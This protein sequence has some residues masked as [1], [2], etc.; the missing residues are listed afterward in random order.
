MTGDRVLHSRSVFQRSGPVVPLVSAFLFSRREITRVHTSKKEVI[1]TFDGGYEIKSAD[2]ILEVLAK[3]HAKGTFFFTGKLIERHP[4]LIK[5]IATQGHEIF[6]HTYGHPNLTTLSEDEITNELEKT[7]RILLATVNLS[8]KPYF[9]AP[10]GA[11]NVRVLAVA[12]KAGYRSVYRTVN[13]LDWKELKG[14]T[15]ASVKER[16]LSRVEPGTIY[17]MHIG[18]TI[19]G[20]I[21]DDVFTAI[22]ARGYHIVSLTQGLHR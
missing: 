1:F 6:N 13:A 3:H 7:E 15:T 5:R 19:T 11:R 9:R 22:E 18:D 21:L 2:K 14:E 10:Y 4:D 20:A 8:T 16:I 12:E 17:L